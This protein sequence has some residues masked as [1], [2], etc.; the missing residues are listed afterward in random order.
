MSLSPSQ[1]FRKGF[2]CPV[3]GGHKDLPSGKGVRC[4]GYVSKDGTAAFCSREEHATNGQ[5]RIDTGPMPLWVHRLDNG[6]S[7]EY[8]ARDIKGPAPTLGEGNGRRS[9]RNHD[10]TILSPSPA[11][12]KVPPLSDD[13]AYAASFGRIE[14]PDTEAVVED[15]E[16]EAARLA[17]ESARAAVGRDDSESNRAWL[18]RAEQKLAILQPVEIEAEAEAES[19]EA[20]PAPSH[21]AGDSPSPPTRAPI[22]GPV[23]TR[24][25]DGVKTTWDVFERGSI[26]RALRTDEA[27]LL[28]IV[29]DQDKGPDDVRAF[30]A[31]GPLLATHRRIDYDDGR[32]KEI[33]WLK[34]DGTLSH[35]DGGVKQDTLPPYRAPDRTPPD[36]LAPWDRFTV[37]VEGEQAADRLAAARE[38]MFM[39]LPDSE[40]LVDERAKAE[41]AMVAAREARDR[42]ATDAEA[43]L[44]D[45]RRSLAEA[46]AGLRA[47]SRALGE[48]L[49]DARLN[50][51][52]VATYGT[53]YTPTATHL[54]EAV[55]GPVYLWPD[56]DKDG[57]GHVEKL[58]LGL[59]D[60]DVPH[61]LLDWAD[62]PPKGDAADF[63]AAH[64][65]EELGQAWLALLGGAAWVAP[66][67]TADE[68]RVNH[69]MVARLVALCEPQPRPN[70]AM[71]ERLQRHRAT[72]GR[73]YLVLES[74]TPS[75]A[76]DYAIDDVLIQRQGGFFYGK[77]GTGKTFIARDMALSLVT[78]EDWH[79]HAVERGPV[80][81]LVGE[82]VEGFKRG[83]RA[84]E[85]VHKRTVS[86]LYITEQAL[87]LTDPAVLDELLRDITKLRTPPIAIFAD[88]LAQHYGDAS[89]N[90]TDAMMRYV[91]VTDRLRAETGASFISLHHTVKEGKTYRGASS[92]GGAMD[93]M[94]AV[95]AHIQ[96]H[97]AHDPAITMTANKRRYMTSV[98]TFRFRL[99]QV[100]L[101]MRDKQGREVTS[102]ALR[103]DDKSAGA[104]GDTEAKTP[105][106]QER[107]ERRRKM[108]ATL[109]DRGEATEAEWL[110][111][112]AGTP[113]RGTAQRDIEALMKAGLVTKQGEGQGAVYRT[114]ALPD[115]P[116]S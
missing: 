57:R 45:A 80:I 40:R 112:C 16:A 95:T 65:D 98:D 73:T 62:A 55:I 70:D 30:C 24:L 7:K 96:P 26:A 20:G 3:C 111:A 29:G 54:R 81:Y 103:L 113:S 86:G 67:D 93:F 78:G 72:Q 84:W 4:A 102:A 21:E 35:G 13:E 114:A 94:W 106:E 6:Q 88:T 66:D 60:L 100:G 61:A 75:K 64:T 49:K 59:I 22:A 46:K 115:D 32:A 10:V 39:A 105:R 50:F 109:K 47:A 116:V 56:N 76:P 18:R 99:N 43:V 2:P 58:G 25:P 82:D 44:G 28:A 104:A 79:G 41:R 71:I 11:I 92:L 17:V 89:E 68:P 34:P 108:L 5:K 101:G 110:A 52:V 77:P 9:E 37:V 53:G 83:R 36:I 107:A 51:R 87:V 42:A 69:A 31:D 33:K 48:A 12:D 23:V 19:G 90:D 14:E 27:G 8:G 38:A 97:R 74:A 1:R 91:R 15:D 63:V 85:I